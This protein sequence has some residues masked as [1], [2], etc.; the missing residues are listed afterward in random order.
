MSRR[1]A[2]S[3]R[4]WIWSNECRCTINIIPDREL[5]YYYDTP[6]VPETPVERLAFITDYLRDQGEA[7]MSEICDD[8]GLINSTVRLT[9]LAHT[10]VFRMTMGRG[11]QGP[12]NL[13][14]LKEETT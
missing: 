4:V 7:T 13:W 3:E 9:L 10:E 12:V 1:Y 2:A 11:K 14:S 5:I 8:L 6:P